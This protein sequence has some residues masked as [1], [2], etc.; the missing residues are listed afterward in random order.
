M[1]VE[2]WLERALADA[3]RRALPELRPLLEALADAMR[4]V[5]AADWNDDASGTGET[6]RRSPRPGSRPRP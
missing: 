3:D 5:R 6:H 4:H 2:H 1:T